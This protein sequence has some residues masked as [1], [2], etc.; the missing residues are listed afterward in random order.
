MLARFLNERKIHYSVIHSAIGFWE[1]GKLSKYVG[2]SKR[3]LDLYSLA[4]SP[5][6]FIESI[7]TLKNIFI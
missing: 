5:S 3:D 2:T 6:V 7:Q 1:V 4:T